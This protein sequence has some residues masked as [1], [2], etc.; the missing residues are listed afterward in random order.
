LVPEE[1]L[2][3]ARAEVMPAPHPE[4]QMAELL[5]ELEKAELPQEPEKAAQVQELE[6]RVLAVPV[7]PRPQVPERQAVPAKE[8]NRPELRNL[9]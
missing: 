2:V 9:A 4:S 8:C 7:E 3:P 1:K 5:Q 6:M